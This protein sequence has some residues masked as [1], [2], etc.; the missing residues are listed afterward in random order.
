M[1]LQCGNIAFSKVPTVLKYKRACAS[2]LRE[3]QLILALASQDVGNPMIKAVIHQRRSLC[4]NI[5][6]LCSALYL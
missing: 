2:K 4:I 5:G 6:K 3:G 1:P